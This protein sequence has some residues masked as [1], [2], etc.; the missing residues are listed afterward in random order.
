MKACPN[1]PTHFVKNVFFSHYL[2]YDFCTICKEDVSHIA[3]KKEIKITR[4][5]LERIDGYKYSP[6]FRNALN[7]NL[8]HLVCGDE[9]SGKTFLT[10]SLIYEH[11][12]DHAE[13]QVIILTDN[14]QNYQNLVTDFRG[15]FYSDNRLIYFNDVFTNNLAL[16][17]ID[18]KK[19]HIDSFISGIMNYATSLSS[20]AKVLFVI[21]LEKSL[22]ESNDL[23]TLVEAI[24]NSGM[25]SFCFLVINSDPSFKNFKN[26]SQKSKTLLSQS[27]FNHSTFYCGQS[28]QANNQIIKDMSLNQ[29]KADAIKTSGEYVLKDGYHQ[30]TFFHYKGPDEDSSLFNHKVKV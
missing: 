21:D 18:K 6:E 9:K 2:N 19:E 27:C 28:S 13:S 7:R 12:Q 26:L 17:N 24:R 8:A 15:Q 29:K 3:S 1:N 22:Q 20:K 30:K 5:K 11:Q 16:I 14:H 4:G 23:D 10:H 25:Y